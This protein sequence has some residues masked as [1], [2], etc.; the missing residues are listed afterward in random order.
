LKGLKSH[1]QLVTK[2]LSLSHDRSYKS[3][4]IS[5]KVPDIQSW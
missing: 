4:S 3:Q 1:N 5:N 2:G